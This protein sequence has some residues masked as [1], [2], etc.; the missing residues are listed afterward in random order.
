M[1]VEKHPR[2]LFVSLRM[3]WS[4]MVLMFDKMYASCCVID[5]IWYMVWRDSFIVRGGSLL[6][7]SIMVS[8][9]SDSSSATCYSRSSCLST[10]NSIEYSSYSIAALLCS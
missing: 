2:Y 10:G 4:L 6:L 1:F 5:Q 9:D 7:L 3:S 8:S